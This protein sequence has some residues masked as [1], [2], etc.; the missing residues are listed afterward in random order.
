MQGT[1]PEIYLE[2]AF[3]SA[4]FVPNAPLPVAE[5]LGKRSIAFLVHPTLSEEHMAE[6]SKLCVSTLK[7]AWSSPS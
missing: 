7:Q 2:E 5:E 3:V 4:G 1:C 6:L